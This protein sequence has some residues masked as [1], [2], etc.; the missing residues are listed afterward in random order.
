[1]S[2]NKKNNILF[3][4]LIN[5]LLLNELSGQ[6]SLPGVIT[7]EERDALLFAGQLIG[8]AQQVKSPHTETVLSPLLQAQVDLARQIE[9]PNEVETVYDV[10]SKAPILSE[11]DSGDVVEQ[12]MSSQG[13]EALLDTDVL[14]PDN[15]LPNIKLGLDFGTAYSKACMVK[16][17]NGEENIL[18]LPLG[19]YAGEDALQMPVHSSLFI[20]PDGRLYFGP[21]AVEKSLDARAAGFGVSRI[22]SIKSFLIDENRVTIDDSPL[23]KIYNPT[24]TDVSKAALLTFYL[25]YLLYLVREAASD[26]HDV[27]I[28]EIQR[29]ISLPCYEPNHRIKVIKEITKLF[30]LGEVLGKS[31]REEWE[32]G[33]RIQDV[34]YLYDWMRLN[35]NKNSPYIECFLE[36]PLAV[37]GS[38][39]GINGSSLGNVCMI[40][41]VGAGTTDFTMFEIFAE[42]KKDHTIATEV[43]GSEYGVPVA[44]DKLDKTL[45]AYI[46]KDAGISRTS[47]KYKEV[48]VSL[49]LDIRDYKER[50]FRDNILTYSILGGLTGQVKLSDFMQEKSIKNFSQEL[51]KAFVHVLSS[52]HPSWIKTKIRQKNTHSKLPVILTGGGANLPMVR[53]LA[54]GTIDVDG[55][56]IQLF[57]SPAVPKWIVDAYKGEIIELYPQMAVSIGSAKEYVIEKTGVQEEYVNSLL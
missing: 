52:I 24:D 46:M 13:I 22:D 19:I 56:P 44:G 29:R 48:L 31:F 50:L 49:R 38:R 36:E 26:R 34:K 42:A 41:D 43:K 12:V 35:I 30:T 5:R 10:V 40:V 55:Y 45:L 39:L 51:R 8:D 18:D 28:S 32:N 57:L 21:I 4:N 54:K 23:S 25:G 27:N 1:M 53:K 37:A 15:F 6:Y 9:P 47:E 11:S 7:E 14:Y 16:V 33:F 17:E 3:E 2:D 20:D